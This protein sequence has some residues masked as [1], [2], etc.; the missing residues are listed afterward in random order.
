LGVIALLAWFL[1]HWAI[2]SIKFP[3]FFSFR[4]FVF[5]HVFFYYRDRCCIAA[6]LFNQATKSSKYE[7]LTTG[8][9]L[10]PFARDQAFF[11]IP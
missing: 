7:L 3:A 8:G 1:A 10:L 4:I 6:K 2:T 11:L 5:I 9:I